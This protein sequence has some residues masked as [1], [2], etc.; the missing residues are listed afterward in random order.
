MRLL[1]GCLLAHVVIAELVPSSWW[2][3]DLTLIGLV[4]SVGERPERWLV[5]SALAGLATMV[6]AIRFPVPV[7][8]GYLAFGWAVQ[9]AA[10]QWDATDER[11]QYL[12]VL[13]ASVLF[14]FG[15]LWLHDRWTF[16]LVGLA[17]VRVVMTCSALP[18]VRGVFNSRGG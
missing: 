14:T 18:L 11:V 8:V 4:L 3:P 9:A 16:M 17:L 7:S 10:R 13:V 5:G 2:V 12:L 6:W 15:A 1:I